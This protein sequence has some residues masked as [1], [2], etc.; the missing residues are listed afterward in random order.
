MENR[1]LKTT[2][3]ARLETENLISIFLLGKDHRASM[4]AADSSMVVLQRFTHRD[5]TLEEYA[6]RRYLSELRS[7]VPESN[8]APLEYLATRPYT[9]FSDLNLYS[10]IVSM[11][12]GT[13]DRLTVRHARSLQS[14]DF[15]QGNFLIVGSPRS[16]PWGTLFEPFLNFRFRYLSDKQRSMIVNANP[17][18]G[19]AEGYLSHAPGEVS[20]E[21]YALVALVP[22]LGANGAVM[23]IAGTSSEATEAAGEFA[24][25][26]ATPAALRKRLGVT[27]LSCVE[28][29]QLVL[30]TSAIG[31]ASRGAV[32]LAHRA[33]LT[34]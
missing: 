22:N 10:R 2:A 29:F 27:D 8:Y 12:P 31:G 34:N 33:K 11:N 25:D 18:P 1:S 4:V 24:L 9:S 26:P 17:R 20:G 15:K 16:N 5:I 3:A 13:V 19:E 23:L 32:V 14:R 7:R 28:S 30:Q 6:E 21:A